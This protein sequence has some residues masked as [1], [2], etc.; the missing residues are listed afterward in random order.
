MEDTILEV[1]HFVKLHYDINVKVVKKVTS[2]IDENYIL[3]TDTEKTYLL[4][5]ITVK[6]NDDIRTQ[7]AI[8][9]VMIRLGSAGFNLP[10]RLAA[11]NG[12]TSILCPFGKSKLSFLVLQTFLQG[13][14][15]DDIICG[16]KDMVNLIFECGQKLAAIARHFKVV[17]TEASKDIQK[18]IIHLI[19]QGEVLSHLSRPKSEWNLLQVD[20]YRHY[21]AELNDQ[22][23]EHCQNAIHTF[24]TMVVPKLSS[25][26]SGFIHADGNACNF[27]VSPKE[28]GWKIT[29]VIDFGDSCTSYYIV[30]VATLLT[31]MMQ[32]AQSSNLDIHEVAKHAYQG[33]I[34]VLPL[35]QDE[36]AVL[37]LV[38]AAR[39]AQSISIGSHMI[40]LEPEKSHLIGQSIKPCSEI[41][42]K[43]SSISRK[44][45]REL[46][47]IS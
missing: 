31:Y 22:I 40:K 26:Q 20:L 23:R 10:V 32:K 14:L 30:D 15:L 39:L 29:G 8:A 6:D 47:A 36:I 34:N 33:Y 42:T 21:V 18:V 45:I 19:L 12:S 27:I 35:N 9:D 17:N 4:K 24:A 44:Q 38:V 16:E 41:L 2:Y 1:R 37:D 43:L 5:V 13:S 28:I 7:K 25:F 11:N 46:W 3:T